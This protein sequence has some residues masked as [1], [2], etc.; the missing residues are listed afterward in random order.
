M[1]QSMQTFDKV[2]AE[3][4]IYVGKIKAITIESS[5]QQIEVTAIVR[6]LNTK[7]KQVEELRKREVAP[8]NDHVKSINAYA[9]ELT[10]TLSMALNQQKQS[11]LAY[12]QV[13]E[14]KRL[15]EERRI[16][17]EEEKKRLE[18]QRIIDE[19]R[20]NSEFEA[21]LGETEQAEETVLVGELQAETAV[22]RIEKDTKRELKAASQ[23]KVSGVTNRWAFEITDPTQ[24]PREFLVPD[25]VKIRKAVVDSKGEVSIAGV[26][27]YQ[28][29]SLS[30]R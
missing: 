8:H 6:D 30:V 13:L 3:V 25:L 11:L 20:V 5:D 12:N 4:K 17:E 1:S 16:R 7:V 27:N 10:E 9:K 19:A 29:Q 24:I 28:E 14:K 22:K 18:A 2:K 21:S 26:R 23:L 15:E